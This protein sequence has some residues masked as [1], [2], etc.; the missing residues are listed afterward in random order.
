MDPAAPARMEQQA[1]PA[2]AGRQQAAQARGVEIDPRPAR[3]P[4]GETRA[5]VARP[6]QWQRH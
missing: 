5:G 3:D 4:P 1:L 6:R 2:L